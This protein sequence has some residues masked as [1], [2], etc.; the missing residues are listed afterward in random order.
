MFHVK[1]NL[2][3]QILDLEKQ[4]VANLRSIYEKLYCEKSH[5]NSQSQ[6]I[7]QIAGVEYGFLSEKYVKK[8]NFLANEMVKGK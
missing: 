6:L 7:R 2:I 8:L 5:A 3:R 1:H 4:S